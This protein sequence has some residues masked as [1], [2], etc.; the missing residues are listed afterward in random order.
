ML[1]AKT[2]LFL[3]HATS[4]ALITPPN[5]TSIA[6]ALKE[7]IANQALFNHLSYNLTLRAKELKW[8]I[9]TRQIQEEILNTF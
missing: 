3:P 5:A 1:D 8:D 7:L 4:G 9:I 6:S 2:S